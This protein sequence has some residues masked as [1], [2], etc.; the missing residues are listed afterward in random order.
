[1]KKQSIFLNF[2]RGGLVDENHI[3][4]NYKKGHLAGLG[5]DVL[6]NEPKVE[7]DVD[8]QNIFLSPH[9]G[10][11]SEESIKKMGMSAVKNLSN[12][13]IPTTS[14]INYYSIS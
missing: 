4:R 1:M 3:L 11:S 9:I 8:K 13:K 12:P 7:I 10:G 14:F 6:K 2:S 5:F